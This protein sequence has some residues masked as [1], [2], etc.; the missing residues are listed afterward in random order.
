MTAERK[1]MKPGKY[2]AICCGSNFKSYYVV[3]FNFPAKGNYGLEEETYE[4]EVDAAWYFLNRVNLVACVE[5]V[6]PIEVFEPLM[7]AK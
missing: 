4:G 1:N 5:A 2:V 6:Y 7:T 3:Q